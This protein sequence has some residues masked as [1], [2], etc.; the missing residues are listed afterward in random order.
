M[1]L[2]R[3]QRRVFA[4][5]KGLKRP[6]CSPPSMQYVDASLLPFI[7]SLDPILHMILT[8][9]FLFLSKQALLEPYRY[10]EQTQGK[11]M[12]DLLIDAF[13]LWFKI[14]DVEL[15]KIKYIVRMLHNASLLYVWME[16]PLQ[17]ISF[18]H[19]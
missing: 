3:L 16:G 14:S 1:H 6:F 9:F 8:Q 2:I 15:T 5:L 17:R 4:L 11:G 19:F 12:R 18:E 10:L 7:A 13:N